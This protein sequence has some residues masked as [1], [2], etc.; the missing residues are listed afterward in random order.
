MFAVNDN[1]VVQKEYLLCTKRE[2]NDDRIDFDDACCCIN[3]STD[4]HMYAVGIYHYCASMIRVQ[5]F[6]ATCDSDCQTLQ[7]CIITV[8]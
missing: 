2:D 8:S 4:V 6:Y 3:D 1:V 5:P 7:V